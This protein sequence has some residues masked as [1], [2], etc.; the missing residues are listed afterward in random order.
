MPLTHTP[1]LDRTHTVSLLD[2]EPELARFIAPAESSAARRATRA[3]EVVLEPGRF[4]PS[5]VLAHGRGGFAAVIASGLIAREIS[6]GGRATLQL[7]GPGDLFS[8]EPADVETFEVTETWAAAVPTH[9]AILDD[10]LLLAIRHWPRLLRGICAVLQ[11][12]QH[13]ALLQLGISH[14]GPVEDR[15]VGLFAILGDRWGR[16]TPEGIT[17]AIPLTHTAIGQM[18][19]ARRPTVTLGMRSLAQRGHLRRQDDGSW[20]LDPEIARLDARHELQP[21]ATLGA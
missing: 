5:T 8:S 4:N 17:I 10:R 18:I 1:L 7:L 9:V 14:I 16:M 21:V 11:Q 6:I 20:L 15:I 12:G 2:I 13:T 3:T 19:G